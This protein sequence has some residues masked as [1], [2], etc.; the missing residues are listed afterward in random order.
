MLLSVGTWKDATPFA[1][2]PN[3]LRIWKFGLHGW[4]R[5]VE[6]PQESFSQNFDFLV[7]GQSQLLT[8]STLTGQQ[9]LR[10][11]R[12]LG[13]Q[14]LQLGQRL[15]L[16]LTQW[17]DSAESVQLSELTQISGQQTS[18]DDWRLVWTPIGLIPAAL[19]FYF[20]EIQFDILYAN[21][22]LWYH[23]INKKILLYWKSN[24]KTQTL[25]FF[26]KQPLHTQFLILTMQK[27]CFLFSLLFFVVYNTQWEG[28]FILTQD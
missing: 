14:L 2:S 27:L 15:W 13:Q 3:W 11:G 4:I 23:F 26:S 20:R 7:N 8:K 17:V 19:D 16:G 28:V 9:L 1:I 21:I 10:L 5:N 18:G 6:K 22:W 12:R 25:L 24:T